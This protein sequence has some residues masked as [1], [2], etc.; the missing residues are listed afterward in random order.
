MSKK[1]S[2]RSR[3]D[4]SRVNMHV[5]TEDERSRGGATARDRERMQGKRLNHGMRFGK[6]DV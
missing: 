2:T 4:A 1:R 6:K 3:K 5:F